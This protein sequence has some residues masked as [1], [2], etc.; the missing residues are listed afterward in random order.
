MPI[1]LVDGGQ[2]GCVLRPS[3]EDW[4]PNGRV[5]TVIRTKADSQTRWSGVLDDAEGSESKPIEA[6]ER[7]AGKKLRWQGSPSLVADPAG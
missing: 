1:E 5:E 3:P 6:G 2:C 4:S 7:V